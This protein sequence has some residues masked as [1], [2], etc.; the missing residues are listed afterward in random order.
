MTI[1]EI[2][3]ALTH[4]FELIKRGVWRQSDP[5]TGLM[6]CTMPSDV[7]AIRIPRMYRESQDEGTLASVFLK[8]EE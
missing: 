8:E 4:G 2:E 7:V 6:I 3:W 1:Q 5:E